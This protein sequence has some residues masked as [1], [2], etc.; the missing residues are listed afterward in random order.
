MGFSPFGYVLPK[1]YKKIGCPNNIINIFIYPASIRCHIF[2]KQ[3]TV[4]PDDM[5]YP[6][7][8]RKRPGWRPAGELP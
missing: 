5:I 1:V 4:S 3:D 2:S 8:H 6:E 7:H